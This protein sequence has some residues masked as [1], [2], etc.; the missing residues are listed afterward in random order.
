MKILQSFSCGVVAFGATSVKLIYLHNGT[1]YVKVRQGTGGMDHF[2]S[3]KEEAYNLFYK[4]CQE[5]LEQFGF[6]R[7][8]PNGKPVRET[9]GY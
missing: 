9:L 7:I 3:N 8:L 2:R 4:Q 5:N 6:L 1:Y